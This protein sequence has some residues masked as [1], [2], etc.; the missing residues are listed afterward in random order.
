MVAISP[1][2]VDRRQEM[3]VVTCTASLEDNELENRMLTLMVQ[4]PAVVDRKQE[5]KAV[6]AEA[7]AVVCRERL[8]D[9]ER[10]EQK[11]VVEIVD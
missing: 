5:M 6:A 11:T 8:P 3:E 1:A 4:P 7:E 9:N 2:V 10:E